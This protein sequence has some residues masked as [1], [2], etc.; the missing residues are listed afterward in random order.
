MHENRRRTSEMALTEDEITETRLNV[1]VEKR[2]LNSGKDFLVLFLCSDFVYFRSI[3]KVSKWLGVKS[4][5]VIHSVKACKMH[6]NHNKIDNDIY[7]YFLFLFQRK[8]GKDNETRNENE[9]T[10]VLWVLCFLLFLSSFFFCS[11]VVSSPI[12]PSSFVNTWSDKDKRLCAS[13]RATAQRLNKLHTCQFNCA[14]QNDCVM[15][16]SV[17]ATMASTEI[18]HSTLTPSPSIDSANHYCASEK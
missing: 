4:A 15:S 12:C 3:N 2:K 16:A 10:R 11:F 18:Q 14:N 13:A 5:A 1:F 9:A 8:S 6:W 7:Y 17:T